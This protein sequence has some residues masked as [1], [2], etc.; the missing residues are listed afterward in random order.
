MQMWKRG[1]IGIGALVALS[2]VGVGGAVGYAASTAEDRLMYPDT[3]MPPITASTD[4]AVIERGRYLV[5]GPAHCAQCHSVPD[6][7]QP[8]R[9]VDHPMSG[10]LAFEMGPIATTWGANLTPDVGTGIGEL[11]DGQVARTIRT[12]ILPDGSL[13]FFMRTS[14]AQLSDE[15]LTAVVSYLRSLEPVAHDVPRGEWHLLG[16]VLLT[17]AFPPLTPRS[18]VG[19]KGVPDAGEPTL[20]RGEYLA[21]S[22]ALCIACHTE[23]DMSTF[24]NVGPKGAGGT[25]EPSHGE[26]SHMEYAPPNLTSHPTGITGKLDEDAFVARLRAGRVHTTSIMPWEGF[27]NTSESDLRSIYLYLRSL[28]PVDRDTGPP[29][30]EVGWKPAG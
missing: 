6:R 15:D 25:V 19:P 24:E 27:Q 20:A 26:D 22:V 28:P 18:H 1:V 29:Y 12:G 7:N 8:E 23:F 30:R 17:Y 9:V 3:P 5:R 13:S 2:A 4:P 10:G 21:E 16:K 14:V 11:T